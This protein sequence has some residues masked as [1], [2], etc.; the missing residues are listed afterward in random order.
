[1]IKER[2]GGLLKGAKLVEENLA[3]DRVNRVIIL[4]D[5]QANEGIRDHKGLVNLAGK[6][7]KKGMGLTCVGVGDDFAEDCQEPQEELINR[8]LE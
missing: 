1:V 5:G 3:S 8:D 2:S 6:I 7:A 4:T